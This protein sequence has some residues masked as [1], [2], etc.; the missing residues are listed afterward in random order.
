MNIDYRMAGILVAA[1]MTQEQIE[2]E[3]L[4]EI[5]PRR[6]SKQGVRPGP[7]TEELYRKR[8][9]D[10]DGDEIEESKWRVVRRKLTRQDKRKLIGKVVE[11]AT[12]AV[13]RNHVSQFEG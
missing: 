8:K 13:M 4:S 7:T 9:F 6:K 11:I 12:Q 5:V 3:K 2:R 1:N 10:E